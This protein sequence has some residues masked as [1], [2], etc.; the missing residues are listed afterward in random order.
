MP[1][2]GC[3]YV[4]TL[5]VYQKLVEMIWLWAKAMKWARYIG[6]FK[7]AADLVVLKKCMDMLGIRMPWK[8]SKDNS[9][10]ALH[11]LQEGS[12]SLADPF[13]DYHFLSPTFCCFCTKLTSMEKY[14]IR[15]V[16]K[17]VESNISVSIIP[18]LFHSS[19]IIFSLYF[20]H[21]IWAKATLSY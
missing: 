9:V 21:W 12:S 10:L 4:L 16:F 14:F 2:V 8:Q 13:E 15:M 18:I 19:D 5:P 6:S 11:V 3:A 20:P 1:P 17:L 7:L